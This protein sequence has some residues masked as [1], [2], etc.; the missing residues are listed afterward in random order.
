[1][2]LGCDVM[3]N[4]SPLVLRSVTI[5]PAAGLM[6][7]AKPVTLTICDCDRLPCPV[8]GCGCKV[9]PVR[10]AVCPNGHRAV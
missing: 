9:D 5:Q 4:C 2:R 1:M 3:C 8:N 7:Y 6:R 10:G